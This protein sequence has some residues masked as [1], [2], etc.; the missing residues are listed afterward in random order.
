MNTTAAALHANVTAATIRTWCRSR[1]ITATKTA[2]RWVIDAASLAH[3]IAIGA[4]KRPARKETAIPKYQV[5]ETIKAIHREQRTVYTVVRTDGTPAGY[6]DGK[7]SRIRD[8]EYG[9]RAN[10][11]AVAEFYERTPAGYRLAREASSSRSMDR[12]QGWVASGSIHGDPGTLRMI[13]RDG[14]DVHGNW[15]EG[16]TWLDILI[17]HAN[18]HAAE[19]PARIAEKAEREAIKAAEETVR[20]AREEQL[21][22]AR[23]EKGTLATPRQVEY[24]LQ[25]LIARQRSGEGGGFYTGPTTQAGIELMSKA[26]ASLYIDSLKGTY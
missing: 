3:R 11:E 14:Q 18:R 1:I 8:A 13:W 16:T 26:E 17:H 10:A 24:I 15:A 21:N 6:G 5:E 20:E 9:S 25:L 22:A 23:R 12:W 2:G 19:A 4:M 7:D